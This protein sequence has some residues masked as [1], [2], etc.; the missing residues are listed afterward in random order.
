MVILTNYYLVRSVVELSQG[1]YVMTL[2]AITVVMATALTV[3]A[4]ALDK[5]VIKSDDV[6]SKLNVKGTE[7]DLVNGNILN[8]IVAQFQRLV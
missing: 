5:Y 7:A 4:I 6:L 2:V 1:S 8:N 3:F